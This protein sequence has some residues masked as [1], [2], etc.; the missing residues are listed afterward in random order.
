M[1][2]AACPNGSRRCEGRWARG[3]PMLWERGYDA[4]RQRALWAIPFRHDCAALK[5]GERSLIESLKA[6]FAAG[7]H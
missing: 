6:C 3:V 7:R 5:P 1:T 4:R 2:T